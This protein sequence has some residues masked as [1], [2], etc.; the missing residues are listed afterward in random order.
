VFKQTGFQQ[1]KCV[2]GFIR[3]RINP[4]CNKLSI[5]LEK[6]PVVFKNSI[7]K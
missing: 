7:K 5:K 6:A 3:G 4:I 2:V 1:V